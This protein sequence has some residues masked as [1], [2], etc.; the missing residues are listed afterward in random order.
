[1]SVLSNRSID[2]PRE[3]GAYSAAILDLLGNREP[4]WG[5]RMRPILSHDRPAISV[6]RRDNIRLFERAMPEDMQRVG[7]HAERGEESV[8]HLYRPYAGHDLAH[9]KQIDR[10]RAAVA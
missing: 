3:R 1:M 4:V 8:A 9:L 7:V 2:P 6:L 5:W 10:I